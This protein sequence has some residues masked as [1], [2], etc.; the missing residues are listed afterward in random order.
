MTD[1]RSPY[2]NITIRNWIEFSDNKNNSSLFVFDMDLS[3]HTNNNGVV[4]T[5]FS[6]RNKLKKVF[7]ALQ[8]N[9]IQLLESGQVV[10][11]MMSSRTSLVDLNNIDSFTWLDKLQTV[12]IKQGVGKGPIKSTCK[13]YSINSYLSLIS[14]HNYIV[15]VKSSIMDNVDILARNKNTRELTGVALD[16]YLDSNG[17]PRRA[18]GTLIILPRPDSYQGQG[19]LEWVRCLKNIG[20][21]YYYSRQLESV[22]READS[23]EIDSDVFDREIVEHCG[24]LFDQEQYQEAIRTAFTLVEARVRNELE[25]SPDAIGVDLMAEAF[26]PDGGEI[27]ISDVSSE[28]QGV[29]QLFRAGFLTFRNPAS[30]RLMQGLDQREAYHILSYTSMLLQILK[31]GGYGF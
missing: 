11:V 14:S 4:P 6:N 26:S 15:K 16:G 21:K 28:Q 24:E 19:V 3:E 17:I 20:E 29:M 1:E 9:I 5:F 2:R 7:S 13:V 31:Q 10:I 30:H 18:S 25:A 23:L 27:S 22:K 12:K 8:E